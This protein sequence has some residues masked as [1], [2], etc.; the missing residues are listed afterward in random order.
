MNRNLIESLLSKVILIRRTEERIAEKYPEQEMR[1]PVHLAI[2]QEA[3]AAGV[4]ENLS[5][6]DAVFSAHRAHSH[7]MGKG[8]DLNKLIAE[9]Y[10]K[11]GGC[12]KGMGGSMHLIDLAVNF[13]GSTPIIGNSLPVAVGSAFSSKLNGKNNITVAFFGD[14]T[15]EEG[16]FHE[17][18]NFA[19]LHKLPI[20]FVCENNFFSVFT[21]ISERQPSRKIVDIARSHNIFAES[22]FG[23]DVVEVYDHAKKAIEYIKSGRGPA[24]LEFS[25]Y[26]WLTHCGHEYDDHLSYRD[27]KEVEE[28]KQKCPLKISLEIARQA[29]ISEEIINKLELE[30]KEKIDRAFDFA[31]ESE[32]PNKEALR[33]PYSN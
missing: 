33:S 9:F 31:K 16:V 10:G 27:P 30:I 12:S 23:N 25:T 2:G 4:C 28:W 26:R 19:S 5:N 1:C 15:V 6:E 18:L 3:I 22:G 24:F 17:S 11:V 7:Y 8:G 20:L 29:D 13:M 14:S 21:H 32:F